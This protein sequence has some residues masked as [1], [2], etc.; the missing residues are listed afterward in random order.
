MRYISAK[1]SDLML[2]HRLNSGPTLN[3]HRVNFRACCD[4]LKQC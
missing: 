2:G 4:S 3:Q 1:M